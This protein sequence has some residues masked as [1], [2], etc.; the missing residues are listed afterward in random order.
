[1]EMNKMTFALKCFTCLLMLTP[2]FIERAMAQVPYSAGYEAHPNGVPIRKEARIDTALRSQTI[3]KNGVRILLDAADLACLSGVP[4]VFKSGLWWAWASPCD[5]HPWCWVGT[6]GDFDRGL[7]YSQQLGPGRIRATPNR[8]DSSW[9]TDDYYNANWEWVDSRG[10]RYAT[11]EEWPGRPV[12]NPNGTSEF[13]DIINYYEP[14]FDFEVPSVPLCASAWFD[15]YFYHCD[16]Y[17]GASTH[18]SRLPNA[19]LTPCNMI[20]FYNESLFTHDPCASM[21][22]S[23]LDVEYDDQWNLVSVP[24][25]VPSDSVQRVFATA[26]SD[27]YQYARAY[28]TATVL[29][30]GRAYWLKY[31]GPA[32]IRLEG[33]SMSNVTV[34]LAEGWNMVG[35]ISKPIHRS[36]LTSDDTT[37]TISDVFGYNGKPFVAESLYPGH[38]YWVK[39]SHGGSLTLSEVL[40]KELS[41]N[42]P[43]KTASTNEMP[44]LPP[45]LEETNTL[46]IPEDYASSDESPSLFSQARAVRYNLPS[47]S[48]VKIVVYNMFGQPVDTLVNQVQGKGHRSISWN[49]DGSAPGVYY[50]RLSAIDLSAPE[51]IFVALQRKLKVD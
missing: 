44:P 37:L 5:G 8:I 30:P 6:S 47:D 14:A 7:Y 38:G 43:V 10:W 1:M 13:G 15:P 17:N 12:V 23:S 33:L 51:K 4:S 19:N 42:Q 22:R 11:Q 40:P 18:F 20:D 50:C 41:R 27:A 35:S 9:T 36:R 21:D 26:S 34:D 29:I 31:A 32:D 24:V 48:R 49:L 28:E 45:M 3:V 46:S 25:L 39:A 2:V 16:Y